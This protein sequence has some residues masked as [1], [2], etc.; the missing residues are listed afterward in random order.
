L[1]RIFFTRSEIV[2]E[3]PE[4]VDPELEGAG[5]VAVDP[6]APVAQALKAL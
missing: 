5:V 4:P 3:L 1:P 2:K 6:H